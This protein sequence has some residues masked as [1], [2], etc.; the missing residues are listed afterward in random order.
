MVEIKRKLTYVNYALRIFNSPLKF[1]ENFFF[2]SHFWTDIRSIFYIKA[3]L[4]SDG[5]A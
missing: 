4:F 5:A 2:S 3:I 1:V